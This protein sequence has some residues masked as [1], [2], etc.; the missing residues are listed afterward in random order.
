[1]TGAVFGARIDEHLPERPLAEA[2]PIPNLP[3]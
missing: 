2:V 3:A 1:M